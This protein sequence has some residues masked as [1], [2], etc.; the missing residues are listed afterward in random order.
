MEV[1]SLTVVSHSNAVNLSCSDKF[2]KG[3]HEEIDSPFRFWL[4]LCNKGGLGSYTRENDALGENP[5]ISIKRAYW[6]CITVWDLGGMKLTFSLAACI[7]LFFRFMNKRLLITHQC[8][9][10]DWQ[11]LH[12]VKGFSFFCSAA[13]SVLEGDKKL[14]RD[15]TETADPNCLKKE[16]GRI[17]MVTAFV[18]LR[19]EAPASQ[20]ATEHLPANGKQWMNSLFCFPYAQNFWFAY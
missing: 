5:Q 10:Y 7:V 15:K 2:C 13:T 14:G 11:F 8:F 3:V 9:G 17:F 1:C 19:S 16:E 6:I 20:K 18:F 4:I 12:S